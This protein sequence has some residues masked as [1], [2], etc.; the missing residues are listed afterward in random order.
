MHH[1]DLTCLRVY[2]TVNNGVYKSGFATTQEAYLENVKSLAGSLDRLNKMLEGKD[3]LIGDTLTEGLKF[4]I[5]V[6]GILIGF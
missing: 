3:Y 2:D 4:V 1:L 6:R 5:T